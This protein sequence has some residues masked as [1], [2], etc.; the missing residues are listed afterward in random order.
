MTPCVVVVDIPMR[1]PSTLNMRE[2]WGEKAK[3][4][5]RHRTAV[6]L[7]MSS[8]GLRGA[9]DRLRE[10]AASGGRLRVI[11]TMVSPR[12]LDSDNLQ[13]SLK[14]VRDSLAYVIGLDDGSPQ[15]DWI[16]LQERGSPSIRIKVEE[17]Q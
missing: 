3:R 14:A 10:L 15:W 4:A 16:Y 17:I 12:R 13:G 7:A 2:H 1:L 5:K 8:V 6:A 11:F 9:V